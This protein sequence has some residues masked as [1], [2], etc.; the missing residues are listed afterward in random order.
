MFLDLLDQPVKD[1]TL[2]PS[3]VDKWKDLLRTT[4]GLLGDPS[5][6]SDSATRTISRTLMFCYD[7]SDPA[8]QK[9]SQ[10]LQYH[11]DHMSPGQTDKN[12]PLNSLFASY[13][14]YYF[15][16]PPF[17]LWTVRST[18]A[19]LEPSNAADME[20]FWM[21][22]TF[23]S[24]FRQ[25]SGLTFICGQALQ[26]FTA[27]LTY[28]SCTEQ[29]R[30]SQVPLTASVIYAMHTIKSALDTDSISSINRPYLLAGTALATS[31]SMFET[32]HQQ[33]ALNLWSD[34]CV[35]LSSSLLQPCTNWPVQD[36]TEIWK[37]QLPLIAALHIDSTKASARPSTAFAQLLLST[38]IPDITEVTWDWASLYNQTKLAGY[39]YMALFKEPIH[40][41]NSPIQDIAHVT[42]QTL[43]RCY[44]EIRLP[45][46]HLLDN[47]VKQLCALAPSSSM[48]L[49]SQGVTNFVVLTI[50]DD[51]ANYSAPRP[52]NPWVLL[53]LDTLFPQSPL[54]HLS[55]IEQLECTGGPEQVH[56]AKARLACHDP[57]QGE[58]CK[59]IKHLKPD[60]H[61]LKLFLWSTDYT[62]CTR[63]FECCLNLATVDRPSSAGDTHSAGTFIQEVL[64]HQWIEHLVQVLCGDSVIARL[65]SW[66]FLAEHMVP[67]WALLP[68]S[69]CCDFASIFLLYEVHEQPVYQSI[70]QVH[71]VLAHQ[72]QIN[73]TF[74]P[75]LAV[76]LEL[77]KCSLNS[78]QLMSFETWLSQLPDALKNQDAHGE[79]ENIL[80]TSKQ[81]ITDEN[82]GLE[83]LTLLAELPMTRAE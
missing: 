70:A 38:N 57:P 48:S 2:R 65:N 78:D 68:P 83:N 43:W 11:F 39:W 23:H 74:L 55:E 27:V 17:D 61:V 40:Q 5:T 6:F 42:I 25:G 15:G 53:H 3:N 73:Q 32:F 34:D 37:F 64:G 20:L 28:V 69:W 79:L 45:A 62:V 44:S 22:N 10:R 1:L 82:L 21:V 41:V 12:K 58:D 4:V 9:L 47:S 71:I 14:H 52:S 56:I 19:S 51:P 67:K 81:Q 18:I 54:L 59:E 26:F 31:E 7:S 49:R 50:P 30:R 35:K 63:A 16:D 33:D 66:N 76:A 60:P 75:F 29:S 72:G 13:L 77:I 46:L 24:S 36:A 8:E 80:A